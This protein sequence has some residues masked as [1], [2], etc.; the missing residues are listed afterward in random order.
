MKSV[1]GLIALLGVMVPGASAQEITPATPGTPNPGGATAIEQA[2][3]EHA[4]RS[5]LPGIAGEDAYKQ[6]LSVRLRSLRTDFGRD[7]SKVSV[8][9]RSTLDSA[10][11]KARTAEGREA[12]LECLTLQ[13][14]AIK[15]RRAP[16]PQASEA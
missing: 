13:L 1:W 11:S 14:A 9:D 12:Y 8:P 6:C 15:S 10:C 7:L 3:I 5:Q 16:T 2:L 4:C